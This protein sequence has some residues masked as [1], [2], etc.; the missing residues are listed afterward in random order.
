M[1]RKKTYEEVKRAFKDEGYRLLSKEYKNNKEILIILCPN[2]HEHE[3]TFHGFQHGRRCSICNTKR[4]N[5]SRKKKYRDVKKEYEDAGYTL[6]SKEYVSSSE[7][8]DIMCPNGHR[9][10]QTWSHF[11]LGHRCKTCYDESKNP[12]PTLNEIKDFLSK[13]GVSLLG[14]EYK[15]AKTKFRLQCKNGHKYSRTWYSIQKNSP[16]PKCTRKKLGESYKKDFSEVL[17]YIEGKG[18]EYVSGEYINGESKLD[19]KCPNGHIFPISWIRFKSG[20]RCSLCNE[21]KGEVAV[22]IFLNKNKIKFKAQK[23]FSKCVDKKELP[24][25][26][27]LP[28]YN[29]LIE[30]NGRQHYEKIDFFGGQKAFKDRKKKDRIKRKF[31]RDNNIKL[32]EIKYTQ[33]DNIE[34]ILKFRST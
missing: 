22:R 23:K 14:G 27:Y 21:S 16:C 5:K 3:L 33:F 28:N 18:Y 6:L 1:P 20:N 30:Y 17:D 25:D 24:F 9:I 26:F 34:K 8:L 2:G 10:K 4:N 19:I 13:D 7:K 12:K 31:C 11:Y 32:I 29:T 15:N